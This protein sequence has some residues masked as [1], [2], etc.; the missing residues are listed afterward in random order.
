MPNGIYACIVKQGVL[1]VVVIFVCFV[2]VYSSDVKFSVF[3][4]FLRD[5]NMISTSSV[6]FRYYAVIIKLVKL[7]KLSSIT[8]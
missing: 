4:L 6:E 1:H 2:V 5:I 8:D 3:L 7:R